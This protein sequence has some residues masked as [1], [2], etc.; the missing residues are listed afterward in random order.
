MRK[1]KLFQIKQPKSAPVFVTHIVAR[2]G[3]PSVLISDQGRNLVTNFLKKC[4]EYSRSGKYNRP[5]HP[6]SNT[7]IER[8]IG[9]YT[10]DFSLRR[11]SR[12]ELG[13][14]SYK[15]SDGVQGN[16]PFHNEIQPPL[17]T[18]R[19]RDETTYAT[20]FKPKFTSADCRVRL[21]PKFTKPEV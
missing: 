19:E 21:Q 18:A 6:M 8:F 3:A 9:H 15:F 12:D 16:A 7:C 2:H 20:G 11:H 10:P 4:A 5:L 1:P 17:L 14:G 13:R